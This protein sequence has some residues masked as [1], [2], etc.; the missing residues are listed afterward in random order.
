VWLHSSEGLE[1]SRAL[2]LVVLPIAAWVALL[3]P[4]LIVVAFVA[5]PPGWVALA[6]ATGVGPLTFAFGGIL[7]LYLAVSGRIHGALAWALAPV[8]LLIAGSYVM[9]ANV[10]FDAADAASIFR[11]TLILYVMLFALAYLLVRDGKLRLPAI[12]DAV[13]ISSAIT[14]TIFLWQ[15]RL[16]PW[17]YLTLD[18]S[19]DVDPGLLFYRT[20]FGYMMALGF[21]VALARFIDPSRRAKVRDGAILGFLS[22]LVA[23]S[24]ARGAWLTAVLLLALLPFRTGKKLHWLILPVVAVLAL[25][26][27]LVQER[28]TSDIS[29]GLAESL[30]SGDFATGRWGLWQDLWDR[31]AAAF[32]EGQGFGYVWSLE[33]QT[34]FGASAFTTEDNPFVYAH[35]DFLYWTVELGLLGLGAMIVFWS[36]LVGRVRTIAHS[37]WGIYA[38]YGFVGGVV[39]TMFVASFVDNGLFIRSVAER[40]F[41]VAGAARATADAIRKGRAGT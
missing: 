23:F 34:L 26:I 35:N 10:P 29:A 4:D 32:P 17:N 18:N 6:P 14:G 28:L 25:S 12:G 37:K 41:I 13:L 2:V 31:G 22:I 40:F 27:P 16:Q 8:A 33:P 11:R 38:G 36:Y 39:L 1:T 30:E 9:I 7:V 24:Y 3:R 5:L 20:H 15:T 21:A 19:G